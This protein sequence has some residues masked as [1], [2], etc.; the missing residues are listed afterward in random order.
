MRT[1][2][3]AREITRRPAMPRSHRHPSRETPGIVVLSIVATAWL[4]SSVLAAATDSPGH[5]SRHAYGF[6]THDDGTNAFEY[7]IIDPSTSSMTSSTHRDFDSLERLAR[8]ESRELFWFS[9]DGKDY[10]VRD[11]G[12][13]ARAR[14]IVA[15]MEEIG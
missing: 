8:K 11:A 9:F 10:V 2:S 13:V 6:R 12:W 5:S 3:A 1:Q 4:S 14:Q 15:P 7:A